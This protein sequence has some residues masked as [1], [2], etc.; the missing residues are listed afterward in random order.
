MTKRAMEALKRKG[1]G[2]RSYTVEK[3]KEERERERTRGV[4]WVS[5]REKT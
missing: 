3:Q 4:G 2:V 1:M 5:E